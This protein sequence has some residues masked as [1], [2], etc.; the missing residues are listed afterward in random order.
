[1]RTVQLR[2]D[3]VN[4]FLICLKCVVRVPEFDN[5]QEEP[6]LRQ[7]TDIKLSQKNIVLCD[8]DIKKLD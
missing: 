2:I 6:T 4:G 3:T 8:M 1:M 7:L 5:S